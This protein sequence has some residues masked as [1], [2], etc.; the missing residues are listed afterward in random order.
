MG[1]L[2]HMKKIRGFKKKHE[3][4][5]VSHRSLRLFSNNSF[6]KSIVFAVAALFVLSIG[7]AI[8]ITF[9][10]TE[11]SQRDIEWDVTLNFTETSGKN[12]YIIFG[13]ALD[14][15][16]G[17]DI[18]DA[19]NPPG[20][21]PPFLDAYFTT[22]LPW[23]YDNL[24]QEIKEYPDTYKE[25]NFTVWWTDSGTTVTISWDTTEVDSSEYESV[26]LCDNAGVPLADMLN[27]N[28]YA[29]FCSGGDMMHFK[30]ICRSNQPPVAND[31]IYDTYEDTKLFVTAPGVLGNDVDTDGP[32][33]LTAFLDDD[34]AYGT[35]TFN[36]DGS[37]DYMPDPEWSGVD[38]FTYHAY[39][40]EYDSNIATVTITVD[41]VND[42]PDAND[43]TATVEEHSSSNQIDVLDNDYDVD[44]DDLE[45]IGVTTP[46]H[47]TATYNAKYVYYTP[48]D[49]YF[50][51]DSFSYTI[52][53]NNGSV[54]IT[55]DVDVTVIE[56]EPPEKPDKPSGE[57]G[58][59]VGEKYTYSSSTTDSNGDKIWYNFSWG[60]GAYSG[61][62][63]PLE[64]GEIGEASHTWD[65]RGNYEIRVKA[66]D[67]HGLESEWSEILP[68]SMPKNKV[69][70]N[71]VLLEILQRLMER[72]PLLEQ[73]LS[74]RPILG[75]LL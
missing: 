34:V 4:H 67:E 38:F 59:K 10:N 5:L 42:D 28:N 23:P 29:F 49:D 75:S 44:G 64:S 61:W 50:G 25:W 15:S 41:P 70:F 14:A 65:N 47:G 37:F 2:H 74:S 73:I 20:G 7:S 48:E 60:D 8:G 21:V 53:D 32:D 31:D 40:G 62:I 54:G 72:F 33:S 39:D 12:D 57:T 43:D 22:S 45:V 69:F 55:A 35:L 36:D 3:K 26:V 27:N 68:I 63:G 30:V 24:M 56:N 6:H 11:N 51:S 52:T 13:E 18:Y 1:E 17:V 66:K 19:P 58:G 71:S 46:S 9:Q 16:D